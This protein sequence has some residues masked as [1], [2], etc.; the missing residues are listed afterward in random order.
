VA[1]TVRSANPAVICGT[2]SMR[3]PYASWQ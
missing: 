1:A 3:N 2:A